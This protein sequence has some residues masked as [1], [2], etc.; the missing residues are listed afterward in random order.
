MVEK[1]LTRRD[2]STHGPLLIHW[3][4]R[5]VLVDGD[6]DVAMMQISL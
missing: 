4:T 2:R 3:T 5:I 6:G 1:D